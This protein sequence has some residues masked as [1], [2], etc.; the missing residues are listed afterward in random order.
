VLW[1]E[2]GLPLWCAKSGFDAP[3]AAQKARDLARRKRDQ[4]FRR[5]LYVAMTRAEDRL[6]I[7]GWRTKQ[8]AAAECWYN[9]IAAGIGEAEGVERDTIDFAAIAGEAG[10]SGP[11]LRVVGRQ[12]TPPRD[13]KVFAARRDRHEPPAWLRLPPPPEPSPPK[14][15]APSQPE[16]E[17]AARSPVE[18]G[19]GDRSAKF[20]RGLL[21]HKLLQSLPDV[22]TERREA[23]ARRFLAR[24][25]HGLGEAEQAA[26]AAETLAVLEHPEFAPLFS[27]E[28]QAEVP[29]VG[30][31][32]GFALAGQIDRL[33]VTEREVLIVDYKTLRPPPATEAEIP[34]V[35]LRQ[36]SAYAAAVAR[37]Y[38]GRRVR[39]AL[40]WTDGPRLMPISPARLAGWAP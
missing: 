18:P 4:E 38:P 36:L 39:A 11:V 5:L 27:P 7:C 30:L 40:L 35:Y 6:Y 26:L 25:V 10:W 9:L 8:R 19:G 33:V 37:V 1:T 28:S 32:D 22:P 24:P 16:A 15:L 29:V 17:P 21:V 14:P 20:R 23:A 3:P 13:D 2:E 31:V 12:A 34:P